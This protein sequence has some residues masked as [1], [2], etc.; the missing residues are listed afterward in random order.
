MHAGLNVSIEIDYTPPDQYP[1]YA[2][3]NYRAASSV[4]LRCGTDGVYGY[5]YYRWSSTCSSCFA[6][7]SYTYMYYSYYSHSITENILKYRDSGVHTCT[8]TDNYGNSGSSS[9]PMNIVGKNPSDIIL[10][11]SL[12]IFT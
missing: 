6:S 11:Y 8:V 4:T 12:Y 7:S 3:P 10:E 5:V 1:N 9:I 2:P